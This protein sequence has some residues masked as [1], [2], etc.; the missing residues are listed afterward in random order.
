MIYFVSLNIAGKY[1]L[2]ILADH[3][4]W[5][6]L[7]WRPGHHGHRNICTKYI[8]IGDRNMR[9]KMLLI[10][11]VC[12]GVL[13]SCATVEQY[14]GKALLAVGG[15]VAKAMEGSTT[16][17]S[18]VTPF[19]KLNNVNRARPYTALEAEYMAKAGISAPDNPSNATIL[20][21]RGMKLLQVEGNVTANGKEMTYFGSGVYILPMDINSGSKIEFMVKG[22]DEEA[23]TFTETY[24]GE[25]ITLTSPAPNSDIDLTKGF[26]IE[27]TPGTDTAK[28]V[29]LSMIVTQIGL[30]NVLPIGLFKDVGQATITPEMLA[31]TLQPATKFKL[32]P[33]ILQ[34]ER[35]KDEIRYVFNGDAIV[36][37]NDIDAIE[38]NVSGN[39]AKREGPAI[40]AIEVK[41]GD[42]SLVIAATQYKY[43][44]MVG[45][46][47]HVD[48]IKNVGLSSFVFK[49]VTGG[50]WEK[51]ETQGNTIITTTKSWGRDFGV[52]V[53]SQMADHLANGIMA[54]MTIGLGAEETPRDAF[55]NTPPYQRM[56][57]LKAKSDAKTFVVKARDLADF[58]SW[59][60]IKVRVG[61][62][63][64]WYFDMMQ[65]S[66]AD[67]LAECYITA[68]RQEPEDGAWD[69]FI[70]NMDVRISYRAYAGQ[71]VM[72]MVIPSATASYVSEKITITKE[73]TYE[74]LLKAF[75]VDSL[76]LA[77]ATAL[78][79]WV[80]ASKA[81][82]G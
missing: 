3:L 45:A 11:L 64:S 28:V 71:V 56:A 8:W 60:N 37:Y 66:G 27:W 20:F 63:D 15:A 69:D 53:L 52:P 80:S 24:M 48:E 16:T 21:S 68:N 59:K 76:M 9:T 14:S 31:E 74:D 57:E 35:Q 73:T 6:I 39:P 44:P 1:S 70:F 65:T 25:K 22:A 18:D 34:L 50:S 19:I 62:T 32:G 10:L 51:K 54:A 29:K 5:K 49:G 38:V 43:N 67:V 78:D 2:I 17:V 77:Y 42:V 13:I 36:S 26:D 61:G 79:K 46:V 30:E 12:M 40:P 23:V 41:E 55:V 4:E 82:E 81:L 33:N 47:A 7:G 72:P 58:S 75:K